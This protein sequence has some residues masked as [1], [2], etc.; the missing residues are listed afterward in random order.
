MSQ[1]DFQPTDD[2]LELHCRQQLSA[3]IDGELPAEEAR[4]LL[5][6]LEHDVE[7]AGCHERW[8]LCGEV[9]RGRACAPAPAGFAA[10]VAQAVAVEPDAPARDT[11]RRLPRWLRWGG[12][13]LAASVAA[14]ALFVARDRLPSEDEAGTATPVVATTARMAAPRV[15]ATGSLPPAAERT[16]ADAGEAVA[17]AATAPA[18]AVAAQRRVASATRSRQAAAVRRQAP[19]ERMVAESAPAAADPFAGHNGLLQARPWPRAALAP[20]GESG[21]FNASVPASQ[22]RSFYP[23]EPRPLAAPGEP[24]S[25]HARDPVPLPRP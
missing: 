5:R 13:A 24:A 19:A 6:R 12:G 11:A 3:L 14:L 9:L 23:F 8:Q 15:D 21:M 2:K 18:A 1:P 16:L 17:S 25:G 4:F 10:R 7:L 20:V 22:A